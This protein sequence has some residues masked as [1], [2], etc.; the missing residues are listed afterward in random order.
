MIYKLLMLLLLFFITIEFYFHYRFIEKVKKDLPENINVE[1]KEDIELPEVD[2]TNTI[3]KNIYRTYYDLELAKK[4]NKAHQKTIETNPRL[5]EKIF[6]D[7]MIGEYIKNNFSNRIYNAYKSINQDYGPA[8]AD[9]FRYLI[10]YKEGGIYLDIKSALIKNIDDILEKN[11]LIIS[12]GKA[13]IYPFH[14]GLISQYRNSY[15]WSYFSKVKYYGEYN[16]WCIISP[17]G[18]QLLAKVIKQMVS[19]IE[20]GLKYQNKY[21]NGEYS[22]LALTGPI[23][24]SRVIIE[25]GNEKNIII[26]DNDLEGKVKY[27][28]GGVDH[29]NIGYKKHYSK[30]KNKKILI[31]NIVI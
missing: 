8:K 11:N 6:D 16:N 17:A 15:N 27:S 1:L 2:K 29:K 7:S 12:R 4:F 3:S 31:N 10:I 14:Y 23:M 18:N 13:N 19:N 25:Y 30:N 26:S 20:Y 5:K 9:F 24:F 28:F 21:N 22:V